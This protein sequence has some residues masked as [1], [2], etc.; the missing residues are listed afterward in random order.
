ML[1]RQTA[2]FVCTH[3]AF[4]NLLSGVYQFVLLIL[5]QK[6]IP[7]LKMSDETETG[8]DGT[9][10]IDQRDVLKI[11]LATDIHLGYNEKDAIRGI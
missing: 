11:L 9:Q 10:G 4:K 3:L 2:Q 7:I 1:F 8:R 5:Y 6:N